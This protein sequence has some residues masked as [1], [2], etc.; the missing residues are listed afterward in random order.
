MHGSAWL[1]IAL[2][3]TLDDEFRAPSEHGDCLMCLSG[4]N[5]QVDEGN[6]RSRIMRAIK[7][8]GNRSTELEMVALLRSG[9][10]RG[11]RRH[12]RL[13]GTPDFVFRRER[14]ALFVDGCFWHACP[15]CYKRPTSNRVFWDEKAERNRVRDRAVVAELRSLGWRV[16]RVWEHQLKDPSRIRSRLLRALRRI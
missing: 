16:I 5:L 10:I 7:G 14:L 6:P 15:R 8:R 11:W 12:A 2:A 4:C 13:P 9:S 3:P 1:A